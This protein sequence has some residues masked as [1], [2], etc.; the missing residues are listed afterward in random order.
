MSLS[1]LPLLVAPSLK[2][3]IYVEVDLYVYGTSEG[4]PA[5]K[6]HMRNEMNPPPT[7]PTPINSPTP[8]FHPY[9]RHPKRL[10]VWWIL[11]VG[12]RLILWRRLSGT[13]RTECCSVG[14]KGEEPRLGVKT[15]PNL[16]FVLLLVLLVLLVLLMLVLVLLLLLV[17]LLPPVL[18]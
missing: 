12:W 9:P 3:S 4:T 6:C 2:T 13:T 5:A 16:I 18:P 11:Y 10:V 8:P 17:L 15:S 7:L 14:E 1:F